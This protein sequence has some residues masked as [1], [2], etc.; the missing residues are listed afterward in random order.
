MVM[1][2]S[3][4]SRKVDRRTA[5]ALWDSAVVPSTLWKKKE[6]D[7]ENSDDALSGGQETMKFKLLTKKGNKQQVRWI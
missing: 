1:E 6:S 4:E 3:A 7:D 5:Q 2:S